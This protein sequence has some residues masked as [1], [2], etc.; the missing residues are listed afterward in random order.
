MPRKLQRKLVDVR[1]RR[2]F[3]IGTLTAFVN[4]SAGSAVV[5]VDAVVEEVETLIDVRPETQG[6]Q[7]QD[8]VARL[9]GATTE[10]P[11]P[12]GKW[13]HI[14]PAVVEGAV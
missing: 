3:E 13:I 12:G 4:G 7:L 1:S 8:D 14:F 5:G 2:E 6:P 9:T 10:D 11:R